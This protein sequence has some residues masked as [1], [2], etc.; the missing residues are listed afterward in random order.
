MFANLEAVN[1]VGGNIEQGNVECYE[2]EKKRNGEAEEWKFSENFK[3][4]E[5]FFSRRLWPFVPA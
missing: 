5:S 2:D 3:I 4:E 1:G